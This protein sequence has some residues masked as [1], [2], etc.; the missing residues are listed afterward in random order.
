MGRYQE[1]YWMRLFS[2]W[3]GN[4]GKQG[5]GEDG[6]SCVLWYSCIDGE[7]EGKDTFSSTDTTSNVQEVKNAIKPIIPHLHNHL[8]KG[9]GKVD[10]DRIQDIVEGDAGY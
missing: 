9:K 5:I 10:G 3:I 8:S 2:V 7:T 4:V 6:S 1:K